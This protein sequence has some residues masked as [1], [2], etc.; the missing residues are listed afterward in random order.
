MSRR[1]W[2]VGACAAALMVTWGVILVLHDPGTA[3]REDE[4]AVEHFEQTPGGKPVCP[5][6]G[7]SDRVG[8]YLYGLVRTVPPPRDPPW[9]FANNCAI[10]PESPRYKCLACG[11]RFGRAR[12]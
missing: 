7:R 12:W 2:W 1:L 3:T 11:T 5:H 8:E 10:T 4:P 9:I 6:S